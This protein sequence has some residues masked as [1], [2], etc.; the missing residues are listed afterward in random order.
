MRARERKKKSVNHGIDRQPAKENRQIGRH[1][2]K[3]QPVCSSSK[4]ITIL[5]KMAWQA[6][7]IHRTETDCPENGNSLQLS[8]TRCS[9]PS[10]QPPPLAA[11][12]AEK[13]EIENPKKRRTTLC[14]NYLST[15][16]HPQV[17][18][19]TISFACQASKYVSELLLF[20]SVRFEQERARC[21]GMRA[22]LVHQ[23]L[24][25]DV[26]GIRQASLPT[27][28]AFASGDCRLAETSPLLTGYKSCSC[29]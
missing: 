17:S 29:Y 28:A 20:R 18:P 27:T 2:K 11:E 7:G 16:S 10:A 3:S 4:G 22:G 8:A 19:L 24:S 6:S 13:G 15:G 21:E 12:S 14:P 23:L 9:I 26:S 1:A 5:G 25:Q